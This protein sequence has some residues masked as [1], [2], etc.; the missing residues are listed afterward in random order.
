M[1]HNCDAIIISCID[2]RFQK[3][4]ED[5]ANKNL[6]TKNYDHASVAGAIIDPFLAIEQIDVSVR[7]HHIKK[8]ILVNHEDCGAYGVSGTYEKHK[9]DLIAVKE[10]VL[11]LYSTLEV[12]LYYLHLDGEFE[13]I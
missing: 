7:L 1:A 10:K 2:F 6:G 4:V 8:A 9:A 5:W 13:K 12:D 3:F 11:K